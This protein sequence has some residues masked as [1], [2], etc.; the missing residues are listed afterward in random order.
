[1]RKTRE[2]VTL[3]LLVAATYASTTTLAGAAERPFG[4]ELDAVSGGRPW[5]E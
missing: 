3:L 1:M 2:W 5:A 4:K